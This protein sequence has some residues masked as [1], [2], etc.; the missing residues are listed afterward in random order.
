MQT[1]DLLFNSFPGYY[2]GIVT[3]YMNRNENTESKHSERILSQLTKVKEL[4]ETFPH[5][6]SEDHDILDMAEKIRAQYKK[7]C[8]LLKIPANN[9]YG[10]GVSF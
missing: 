4:I 2:L 1:T 6:N 3:Y 7:A 8:A 9:P 10:A 5:T